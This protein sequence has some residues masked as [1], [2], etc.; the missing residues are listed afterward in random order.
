MAYGVISFLSDE[1]REKM[2]EDITIHGTGFM[3]F[4]E[5]GCLQRMDPESVFKSPDEIWD[6]NA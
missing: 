4:D 2:I 1:D 5:H 6:D 3:K